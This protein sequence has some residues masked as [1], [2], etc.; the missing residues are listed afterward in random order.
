MTVLD[1]THLFDFIDSTFG[2][3]DNCYSDL[4]WYMETN[5]KNIGDAM[6]WLQDLIDYD[7]TPY[8]IMYDEDDQL[9]NKYRDPINQLFPESEFKLA[10]IGQ[11]IK[12][13]AVSFC[14]KHHAFN[15]KNYIQGHTG[16][17]Y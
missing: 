1:K 8:L 13:T 6:H 10:S 7:C 11:N 16:Y 9:F 15:L 2:D 4:L 14:I 17:P 5:F 12:N 3:K